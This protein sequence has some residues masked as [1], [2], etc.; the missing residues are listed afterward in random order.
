[1]PA[2]NQVVALALCF[3]VLV[4]IYQVRYWCY[5]LWARHSYRD[6]HDLVGKMKHTHITRRRV[7]RHL[8]D[9]MLVFK[10]NEHHPKVVKATV[11]PAIMDAI[12][13]HQHPKFP[14]VDCHV[15]DYLTTKSPYAFSAHTDTEWNSLSNDGYQVWYLISNKNTENLGNMFIIDC[16]YLFDKYSKNNIF[17]TLAK[18]NDDVVVSVNRPPLLPRPGCA[19]ELERI[20]VGWFV[21]N[22]TVYYLDFE[23][24]D[25]LVFDRGLCHMTDTRDRQRYAVNFRVLVGEPRKRDK[26]CGFL[27]NTGV[28]YKT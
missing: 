1:M 8:R 5:Y 28:A 4:V 26:D 19:R 10:L 7:P 24:G 6:I 25:C 23:P 13:K 14:T 22:T 20:P 18:E 27:A 16:P 17:Y 15:V 12:K 9:R 2:R 21:A 11:L 3:V